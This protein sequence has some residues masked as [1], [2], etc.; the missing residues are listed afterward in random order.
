MLQ[1][2]TMHVSNYT[3]HQH[4]K[5]LWFEET[6][7]GTASIRT[8]KPSKWLCKLFISTGYKIHA[9]KKHVR[10]Q[11]ALESSNQANGFVNCSFP[12]DTR[13]MQH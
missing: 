12:L 5:Q 4:V 1:R 9:L 6:C 2:V 8:I 3:M 11:L 13:F 7:A 10:V